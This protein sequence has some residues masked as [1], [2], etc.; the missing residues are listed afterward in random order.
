MGSC[1]S[2]QVGRALT[3]IFPSPFQVSTEYDVGR[4]LGVSRTPPRWGGLREVSNKQEFISLGSIRGISG[5]HWGIQAG[6]RS[7]VLIWGSEDHKSG[8]QSG[9][10][11]GIILEYKLGYDLGFVPGVHLE[12]LLGINLGSNRGTISDVPG[13]QSGGLPPAQSQK[14]ACNVMA[15]GQG[16]VVTGGYRSCPAMQCGTTVTTGLTAITQSK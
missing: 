8:V 11:L 7:G 12:Y 5:D 16:T 15:F 14:N 9:W 6:E 1:S 13:D 2:L 10:Y 3:I 4:R